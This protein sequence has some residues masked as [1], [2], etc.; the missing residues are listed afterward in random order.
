[1]IAIPPIPPVRRRFVI[2]SVLSLSLLPIFAAYGPPVDALQHEVSPESTERLEDTFNRAVDQ[3]ANGRYQEGRELLQGLMVPFTGLMS[4]AML[5]TADSYYRED[6]EINRSRAETQY[7]KWLL[8]FPNDKRVPDVRLKIAEICLRY[9][10]REG[11]R[12]MCSE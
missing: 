11:D 7:G 5:L 4:P 2:S 9:P 10:L 3:I 8:M 1:M 12:A 6:G